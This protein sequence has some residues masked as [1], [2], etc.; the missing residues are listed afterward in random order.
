VKT[1][2]NR[3][4]QFLAA[5]VAF[6][7]LLVLLPFTPVQKSSFYYSQI[8][9]DALLT[10]V[11]GQRIIFVGGSNVS[12]GINSQIFADSL[13][14]H[15]INTAIDAGVGLVYMLDHTINQIHKGDIV[16]VIPEYDHFFED[17]AYGG[18]GDQLL[19]ESTINGVS[20]IGNLRRKQI[21]RSLKYIPALL[22]SKLRMWH[23]FYKKDTS[24][25]YLRQ[26]FNK[27]GDAVGHWNRQSDIVPA[28][29]SFGKSVNFQ[30]I[31]EIQD[32]NDKVLQKGAYCLFTFPCVQKSTYQNCIAQVAEVEKEIRKLNIKT[33]GNPQEYVFPDEYMFNTIYHL[34][35]K[36]V[37]VRT[38]KLLN[39]LKQAL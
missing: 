15:P 3:I 6:I 32:F 37:D 2:F 11:K 4:L 25:V 8:D 14:L 13:G 33:F 34:N 10:S 18:N 19:I 5:L 31:H 1:F 24:N 23:Y 27:Y 26:S 20:N 36:G 35:K 38:A 22:M 30:I 7:L 9:K 29:A 28:V 21:A 16:V 17:F 12:F 39:D